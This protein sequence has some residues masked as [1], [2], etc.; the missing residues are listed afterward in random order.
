MTCRSDEWKHDQRP[1]AAKFEG[2][3]LRRKAWPNEIKSTGEKHDKEENID[4]L[5]AVAW[6]RNKSL[7]R[8][9][10]IACAEHG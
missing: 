7:E 6:S 4:M 1:R 2:M 8:K 10:K 5:H 9:G 3:P